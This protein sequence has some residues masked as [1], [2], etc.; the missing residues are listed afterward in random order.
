[1]TQKGTAKYWGGFVSEGAESILLY[2]G[3][4]AKWGINKIGLR[5]GGALLNQQRH[6]ITYERTRQTF[7]VLLPGN[8]P[9]S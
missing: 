5:R 3:G 2:I 7:Q 1:M 6:S 8:K 4:N 9:Y